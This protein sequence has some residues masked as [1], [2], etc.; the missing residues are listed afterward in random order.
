MEG[1]LGHEVE[2]KE[3]WVMRLSGEWKDRLVMRSLL[4]ASIVYI[5]CGCL[6]PSLSVQLGICLVHTLARTHTHTHTHTHTDDT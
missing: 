4:T 1:V 2:W 3:C 6:L 5:I